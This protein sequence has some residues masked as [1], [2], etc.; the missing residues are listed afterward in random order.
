M[1]W[2]ISNDLQ[3]LTKL[4]EGLSA[5]GENANLPPSLIFEVTLALEEIVTN[6]V[7]YGYD[8]DRKHLISVRLEHQDNAFVITV[9]DDAKA[10]NPLSIPTPDLDASLS[11]RP[12]GGLGIHLVRRLMD[13]VTYQRE[14]GR[15]ILVMTKKYE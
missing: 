1:I 10:F 5:F 6:I 2:N 15:N 7:S 14:Q 12:I 3:E 4:S 8:D 9:E 11:D 13:N